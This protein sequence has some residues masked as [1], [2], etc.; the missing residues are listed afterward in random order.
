[1]EEDSSRSSS[2]TSSS[3]SPSSS[4][5]DRRELVAGGPINRFIGR[6]ETF[7]IYI[8]KKHVES[9]LEALIPFAALVDSLNL[10]IVTSFKVPISP[11]G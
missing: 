7:E 9:G 1:M 11:G 10:G 6:V 2:S 4:S 3:S 5:S 8:L